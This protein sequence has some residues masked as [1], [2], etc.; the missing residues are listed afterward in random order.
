MP[1]HTEE[2]LGKLLRV[3]MSRDKVTNALGKPSL[4]MDIDGGYVRFDYFFP[5]E[6]GPGPRR[7]VVSGVA[8]YL[9]DDKVVRWG[10]HYGTVGGYREGDS[11][12]LVEPVRN[13]NGSTNKP[14]LLTIWTLS[15]N[16]IGKG[17]YIDT[18]RLPQAG[19]IPEQPD[20][21]IE[22]LNE[23]SQ[24]REVVLNDKDQEVE[25]PLLKIELAPEDV[26]AFKRFTERNV[27]KRILIMVDDTPVDALRIN[28]PISLGRFMIC[29]RDQQE[30]QQLRDSLARLLPPR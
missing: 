18:Q 17:R 27:G 6:G 28:A 7:F 1:V 4:T 19:F 10:P 15:T 20:L 13:A 23:L 11:D 25:N 3:G 29:C 30:F 2:S 21:R 14:L 8:V 24:S 22:R 12:V 26:G 5:Y 9:K 16:R